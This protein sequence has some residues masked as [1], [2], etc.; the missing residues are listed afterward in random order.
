[1]KKII[2]LL[3]LIGIVSC[4]SVGDWVKDVMEPESNRDEV[5]EHHRPLESQ[6]L[7]VRPGYEGKLTNR[8]CVSFYGDECEKESVREYDLKDAPTRKRLIDL[9]FACD[10]GGSRY[11]ICPDQP[12]LCRREKHKVCKKWGRT[13]FRRK[14]VCRK[15]KEEIKTKFISA[16]DEYA[17]LLDSRTECKKGL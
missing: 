4:S 13:L 11:R 3:S 12:G 7:T 9:K 17:F 6:R 14:K 10:V 16:V 1:M 15:W 5:H 2:L 8:V